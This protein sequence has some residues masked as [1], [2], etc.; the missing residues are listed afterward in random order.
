MNEPGYLA[1]ELE[2]E[3]SKFYLIFAL[4]ATFA[5]PL[6]CLLIFIRRKDI[7]IFAQLQKEVIKTVRAMPLLI[8]QT[9]FVSNSFSGLS[10]SF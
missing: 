9:N 10:S 7:K 1:S 4:I 5:V 8:V 2:T 3:R 6:L